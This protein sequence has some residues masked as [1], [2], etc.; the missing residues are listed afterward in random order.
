M[1]CIA[2]RGGK[3]S[4]SVA[5]LLAFAGLRVAVLEGGYKAYRTYLHAWLES[6]P[7]EL[8]ILGGA[9]G[10]GKTELL[11]ALAMKGE[12][13]LD[14]EALANHKGSAF[15]WIGEEPQPSTEEYENRIFEQLRNMDT[16]R[17]IWVENESRTVGHVFIPEMFWDKM[18]VSPLIHLEVPLHDRVQ[19]LVRTYACGPN[20]K[21]LAESFT[22]IRKRLGGQHLNRALEALEKEDYTLAAEIALTYYDKTYQYGLEQSSAAMIL[23][24]NAEGMTQEH[25]VGELLQAAEHIRVQKYGFMSAL[26]LHNTVTAPV[27]VARSLLRC[28]PHIS[29][30]LRHLGIHNFLNFL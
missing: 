28:L 4:S 14:L 29:S 30:E 18:R 25:I 9:T 15:G 21:A 19:H 13:V 24:L 1:L 2:G 23:N 26:K 16:R 8:I 6:T 12:Q 7:F 20:K 10:S 22:R 27:V 3:R 17:R 5:W 11:N